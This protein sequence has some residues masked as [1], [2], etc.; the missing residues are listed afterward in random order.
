M[1]YYSGLAIQDS[2]CIRPEDTSDT[3]HDVPSSI[4]GQ[5][6]FVTT[7]SI[8]VERGHFGLFLLLLLLLLLLLDG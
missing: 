4:T 1:E 2:S 8:P 7:H 6:L 5:A 3:P